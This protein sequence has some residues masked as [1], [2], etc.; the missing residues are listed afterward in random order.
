[1]AGWNKKIDFSK[2]ELFLC[3]TASLIFLILTLLKLLKIEL[4]SWQ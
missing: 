4:Q 3:R 1:M 2:I